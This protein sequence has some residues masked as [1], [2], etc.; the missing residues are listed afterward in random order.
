[1]RLSMTRRLMTRL[2][3]NQANCILSQVTRN[4]SLAKRRGSLIYD[5]SQKVR[6]PSLRNGW[7][8]TAWERSP[9]D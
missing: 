8:E 2:V 4:W 6:H 7:D 5:C 3:W 9:S 1:M